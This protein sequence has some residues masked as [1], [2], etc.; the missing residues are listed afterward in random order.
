MLYAPALLGTSLPLKLLNA[1]RGHPDTGAD[2]TS[3]A[4]IRRDRTRP[5]YPNVRLAKI[6]RRSSEGKTRAYL[7]R[8]WAYLT[9]GTPS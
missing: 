6:Y 4:S 9:R 1:V 5:I 2:A 3:V 7:R 8:Y